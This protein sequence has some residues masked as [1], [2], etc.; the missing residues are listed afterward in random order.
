MPAD[1]VWAPPAAAWET[2]DRFAKG[3]DWGTVVE[4]VVVFVPG[5]DGR[6]VVE[7]VD[8]VEGDVVDVDVVDAV[9]VDDVVVP[10][11]R[12]VAAAPLAVASTTPTVRAAA[13]SPRRATFATAMLSPPPVRSAGPGRTDPCAD[14][15]QLA[16]SRSSARIH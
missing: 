11:D 7:V 9:V 4:V 15:R 1:S 8:V 13:S 3:C 2:V 12:T 5:G 6:D 16:P 14:R 10:T